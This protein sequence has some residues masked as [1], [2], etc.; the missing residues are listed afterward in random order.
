MRCVAREDRKRQNQI[1]GL[2]ARI[3]LNRWLAHLSPQAIDIAEKTEWPLTIGR[4]NSEAGTCSRSEQRI[5]LPKFFFDRCC[6]R[7]ATDSD[8]TGRISPV[9]LILCFAPKR[10]PCSYTV[11]FGMDIV[12]VKVDYQPQIRSSGNEKLKL[13]VRGTKRRKTS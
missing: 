13:I 7:R 6:T 12:A 9:P 2:E 11:A 5:Q 10:L 8:C 4:R 3:V 1:Y